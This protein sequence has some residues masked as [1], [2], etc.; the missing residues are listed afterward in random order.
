MRWLTFSGTD[1]LALVPE[2]G[3]LLSAPPSYG[4]EILVPGP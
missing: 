2:I 1:T 4:I 3:K